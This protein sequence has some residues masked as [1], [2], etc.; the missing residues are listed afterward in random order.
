MYDWVL[1]I[2]SRRSNLNVSYWVRLYNIT[3]PRCLVLMIVSIASV[4]NPCRNNG[5][6]S[7]LCLIVPNGFKCACPESGVLLPDRKNCKMRMYIHLY[8]NIYLDI[9]CCRGY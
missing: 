8:F 6:C 3:Y 5:G 7:H 9:S 2:Y 1:C 4:T